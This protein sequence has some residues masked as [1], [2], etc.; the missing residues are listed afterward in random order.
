MKKSE[1]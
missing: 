1:K